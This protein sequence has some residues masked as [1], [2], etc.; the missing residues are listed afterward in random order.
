MAGGAQG[1]GEA[2]PRE[3]RLSS[4]TW[5]STAETLAKALD[6]R[7]L[8]AAFPAFSPRAMSSPPAPFPWL[9]PARRE[10]PPAW[11]QSPAPRGGEGGGCDRSPRT[12]TPARGRRCG[13]FEVKIT[14]ASVSPEMPRAGRGAKGGAGSGGKAN[15]LQAELRP[16]V[17]QRVGEGAARV[18]S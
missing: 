18:P 9:L 6:A 13:D 8:N 11:P 1:E 15:R 17:T 3:D 7:P 4:A 5:T 12:G 10:P 2:R 16:E 14:E